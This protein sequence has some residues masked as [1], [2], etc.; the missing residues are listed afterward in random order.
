M[1]TIL[2]QTFHLSP[3]AAEELIT[4]AVKA[5]EESADLWEFT[6]LINRH[7]STEE[8]KQVLEAAWQVIFADRTLDKYEDHLVHKLAK[9]LRLKHSDLIEAK[10]KVKYG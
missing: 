9:L 6:N 1:I 7:Y 4:W 10:M 8:K 5:R 3:P 2:E